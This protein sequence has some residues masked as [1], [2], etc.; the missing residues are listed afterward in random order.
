[1][2]KTTNPSYINPGRTPNGFLF[3]AWKS[4]ILNHLKGISQGDFDKYNET[5]NV[6]VDDLIKEID[7]IE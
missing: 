1:M 4:Y 5:E 3:A 6:L 2:D 7:S